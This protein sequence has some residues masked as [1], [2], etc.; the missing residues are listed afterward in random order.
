MR[1]LFSSKFK[2]L[3]GTIWVVKFYFPMID[4]VA[5]RSSFSD[6]KLFRRRSKRVV[7]GTSNLPTFF[8]RGDHWSQ[9]I[10]H[11][12]V[13]YARVPLLPQ[14]PFS[15]SAPPSFWYYALPTLETLPLCPL[16]LHPRRHPVLLGLYFCPDP[17][18]G[19][20]PSRPGRPVP[21]SPPPAAP[22]PLPPPPTVAAG[23]G[24]SDR[25]ATASRAPPNYKIS[26]AGRRLNCYRSTSGTGCSSRARRY[27]TW[28]SPRAVGARWRWR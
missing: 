11:H 8:H 7:N 22:C 12:V 13:F 24:S 21:R 26:R 3:L 27:S 14:L 18:H 10:C 1:F 20:E 2:I 25:A 6:T 28:A 19:P 16:G 15:T 23:A 9:K 17:H 4:G 5:R